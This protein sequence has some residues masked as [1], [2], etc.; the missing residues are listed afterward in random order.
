MTRTT[1]TSSTPMSTAVGAGNNRAAATGTDR[2]LE[3]APAAPDLVPARP[4]DRERHGKF[5]WVPATSSTPVCVA[6]CIFF[7][8]QP[9]VW[10]VNVSVTDRHLEE[11]LE[12]DLEVD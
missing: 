9:A 12:T 5:L 10:L 7:C 3:G 2:T 6:G 11:D 1:M 4:E 8:Q